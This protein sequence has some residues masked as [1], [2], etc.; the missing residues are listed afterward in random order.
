MNTVNRLPNMTH[1][2]KHLSFL[3]LVLVLFSCKDN[4]KILSEEL[5]ET[6]TDVDG[7]IYKTIKIGNQVWMA[8]NLKTTKYTDGTPITLYSFDEFGIN[9]GNLN[10]EVGYYQWASTEDLNNVIDEELPLDYYGA[11]YNHF[12]L[13]SG[14]LAPKG[15]RIPTAEDFKVLEAFLA[16]EG[17]SGNEA[18]VL[19]SET[20]WLPS[21]GT[22]TNLYGFNGL[23]NGYVSAGGT[24]TLGQ[25]ICTWSTSTLIAD[26]FGIQTRIMI[27]LYDK[28]TIIY[29]ENALQIGSA[30]RC[31]KD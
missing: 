16:S 27:S 29:D 13:I 5:D 17:H 25:G 14:K 21:S 3:V 10:E 2:I 26:N 1:S 20:G 15:W 28:S 18:T 4:N 11:M 24:S 6:V 31:I 22:G 19:K 8:E 7:N 9:W 30:I 12:A 23:P